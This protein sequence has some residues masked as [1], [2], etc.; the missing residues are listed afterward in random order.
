MSQTVNVPECED[1][2][3]NVCHSCHR[4]LVGMVDNTT[5]GCVCE[6]C[7]QLRE[8]VELLKEWQA[9]YESTKDDAFK[10][11]YRTNLFHERFERKEAERCK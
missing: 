1:C 2:K 9:F 3:K 8:A 10:L 7:S 6:P 5:D 4:S 11:N